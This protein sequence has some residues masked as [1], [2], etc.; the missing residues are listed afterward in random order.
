MRNY[1]VE[2]SNNAHCICFFSWS[3]NSISSFSNP[4]GALIYI[5]PISLFSV[6]Y[7]AI[8][9]LELRTEVATY[10][11]NFTEVPLEDSSFPGAE[12]RWLLDDDGNKIVWQQNVTYFKLAQTE[13]R[14]NPA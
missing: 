12:G 2:F 7:N 4:E 13:L 8:R 3:C 1:K 14:E 6:V 10:T 5:L 9:F 11:K